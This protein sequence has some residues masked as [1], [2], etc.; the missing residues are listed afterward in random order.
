MS[1]D[2]AALHAL[3]Q[4]YYLPVYRPRRIVLDHGRGSRLWDIEGRITDEKGNLLAFG[5]T[6]CLIFDL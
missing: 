3:A 5:T 4:R 6:T 1:E 2:T